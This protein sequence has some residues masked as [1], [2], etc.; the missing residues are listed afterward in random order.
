MEKI[1]SKL[2]SVIDP[3]ACFGDFNAFCSFEKKEGGNP[4]NPQSLADFNA[5]I[6]DLRLIDIGFTGPSFTWS[7]NHLDNSIIYERLDRFLLNDPW[8]R[9]WPESIVEHKDSSSSDHRPI[10]LFPVPPTPPSKRLFRFDNRWIEYREACTLI[11]KAWKLYVRGT[12]MYRLKEKIKISKTPP[13]SLVFHWSNQFS[14][15][16]TRIRKKDRI[17]QSSDSR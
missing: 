13:F 9:Q 11:A 3:I 10:V 16:N 6:N 4:V 7:N 2:L 15:N 5:F 14:S 8:I 1:S 12:P 17:C